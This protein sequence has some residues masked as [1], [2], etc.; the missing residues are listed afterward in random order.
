MPTPPDGRDMPSDAVLNAV[1]D[2]ILATAR[3]DLDDQQ[4]GKVLKGISTTFDAMETM[5]RV[6]LENGDEPHFIFRAYNPE[7]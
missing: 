4:I 5:Q 2:R 7:G 3:H 6:E 1:L